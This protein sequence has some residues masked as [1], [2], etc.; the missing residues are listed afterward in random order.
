MATAAALD[1]TV[2]TDFGTLD[3]AAATFV[4][5]DVEPDIEPQSQPQHDIA[6][7]AEVEAAPSPDVQMAGKPQ[8]DKL[9]NIRAQ[10]KYDTDEEW[11]AYVEAATG[12]TVT[13]DKQLTLEQADNLI[14]LFNEDTEA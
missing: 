8:L 13:A 1:G 6:P 3:Q 12:A 4:D 14:A 7:P 10:E 2:R 9:K 11:F 5:G